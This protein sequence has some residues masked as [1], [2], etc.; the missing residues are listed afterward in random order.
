MIALALALLAQD[1]IEFRADLAEALAEAKRTKSC[2]LI[3]FVQPG[4]GYCARLERESLSTPEIAARHNRSFV[5]VKL[6][7]SDRALSKKYGV[8]VTP[9]AV[10]VDWQG[11]AIW[12]LPG[13]VPAADYAAWLRTAEGLARH[14]EAARGTSRDP[15]EVRAVGRVFARSSLHAKAL[16]NFNKALELNAKR[17]ETADTRLFRGETLAAKG[18]SHYLNRGGMDELDKIG[19]ELLGMDPEGKLGVRDNGL[20]LRALSDATRGRWEEAMAAVDEA[21]R[22]D[23]ESDARDGLLYLRAYYVD[24]GEGKPD[25]ARRLY[26]EILEKHPDSP[27]LPAVA[28][29]MQK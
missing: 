29:A 28:A 17:R 22:L 23:P 10:L 4:C 2:V 24:K 11:E 15:A 14:P 12:R 13:Y 3:L 9:T 16:E 26:E 1:G 18:V 21:L 20:L 8:E 6:A 25:E 5:N 19:A 27:F 7:G